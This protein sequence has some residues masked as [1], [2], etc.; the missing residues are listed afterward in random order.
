MLCLNTYFMLLT[1]HFISLF[2]MVTIKYSFCKLLPGEKYFLC[3]G[4]VMYDQGI[5]NLSFITFFT[6]PLDSLALIHDIFQI[7]QVTWN[8][9]YDTIMP[10]TYQCAAL[11]HN[12]AQYALSIQ[13]L[14]I[15]SRAEFC[16]LNQRRNT[17]E[18]ACL[19][20]TER[21]HCVLCTLCKA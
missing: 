11:Q 19:L 2:F 6:S 9:L 14:T 13:P 10:L 5:T 18:L 15:K 21:T 17:Y 20:S 3:F 4:F 1:V 8:L 7:N 12:G 16:M